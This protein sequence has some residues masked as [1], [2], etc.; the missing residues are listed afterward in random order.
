MNTALQSVF[1]GTKRTCINI[2][3]SKQQNASLRSRARY[4]RSRSR[5]QEQEQEP[6]AKSRTNSLEQEAIMLIA[7]TI[8]KQHSQAG[9]MIRCI[10]HIVPCN[11]I[12]MMLPTAHRDVR[13]NTHIYLCWLSCT[14]TCININ[15]Y[16]QKNASLLEGPATRGAGAGAGARSQEQEKELGAGGGSRI[17]EWEQRSTDR[18]LEQR[19]EAAAKWEDV[20]Y[21]ITISLNIKFFNSLKY[22]FLTP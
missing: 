6:K 1:L 8:Q 10:S 21:R 19:A 2:N 11:Y 3:R 7:A 22:F 12:D 9:A 16:K 5:S 20:L 17:Q 15:R 4:K 18:S 14:S 13:T